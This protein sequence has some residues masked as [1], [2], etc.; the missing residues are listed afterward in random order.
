MPGRSR[1]AMALAL[2]SSALLSLAG[3]ML[4]LDL[5]Q[6]TASRH[7]AYFQRYGWDALRMS[8][9]LIVFTAHAARRLLV[10]RPFRPAVGQ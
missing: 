3:G 6:C 7:V 9:P 8:L 2:A 10:H 5:V 1:R 4:L